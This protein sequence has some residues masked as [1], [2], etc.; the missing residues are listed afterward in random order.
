[1]ILSNLA[2]LISA[3]FRMGGKIL[4]D[5]ATTGVLKIR[6][7]A[8]SAFLE[9]YAADPTTDDSLTTKRYVDAQGGASVKTI[10]IPFTF[11]AGVETST[12]LVPAGAIVHGVDL[13]IDTAL[14][15]T[16]P[17]ISVGFDGGSA[18][19]LMG[20]GENFPTVAALQQKAQATPAPG[21][22]SAVTVTVGGTGGSAGAGTAY[23]F[24]STPA[25]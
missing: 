19:A 9:V 2:G 24:Y 4:L 5:A 16:A 8:D 3:T 11:S 10:K 15:S 14:N 21:A 12:E 7:N 13:Q 6:N 22:D 17:T 18:T 1:M 23:I 25:A 20:T